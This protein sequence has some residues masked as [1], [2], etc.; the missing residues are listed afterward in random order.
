MVWGG[1]IQSRRE[2]ML[3]AAVQAQLRAGIK[4][5]FHRK[6]TALSHEGAQLRFV[7][8]IPLPHEARVLIGWCLA[9]A[10]VGQLHQNVWH[11]VHACRVVEDADVFNESGVCGKKGICCYHCP[12]NDGFEAEYGYNVL[13]RSLIKALHSAHP[14]LLRY[15]C[16]ATQLGLHTRSGAVQDLAE[17][18]RKVPCHWGNVHGKVCECMYAPMNRD[19][20]WQLAREGHMSPCSVHAV[21]DRLHMMHE[22]DEELRKG[23]EPPHLAQIAEDMYHLVSHLPEDFVLASSAPEPW[24]PEDTYLGDIKQCHSRVW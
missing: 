19:K 1:W 11:A 4:S 9:T 12:N 17:T 18:V 14:R 6:I 15:V 24:M 23:S 20:F 2:Q 3:H 5:T 16:A 10:D 7:C 13:T 21:K 8:R 22:R